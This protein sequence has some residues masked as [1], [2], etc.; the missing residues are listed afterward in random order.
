MICRCA[1]NDWVSL[2]CFECILLRY[3]TNATNTE[4][5]GETFN[6]CILFLLIVLFY[7]LFLRLPGF[8]SGNKLKLWLWCRQDLKTLLWSLSKAQRYLD[9]HTTVASFLT[10]LGVKWMGNDQKLF[11]WADVFQQDKS[12]IITSWILLFF[13]KR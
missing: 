7:C 10:C 4:T 8:S 5:Q 3:F 13:F 11:I 2:K 6:K 9:F 1:I 12:Q